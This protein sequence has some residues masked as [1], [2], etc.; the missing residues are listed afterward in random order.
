MGPYSALIKYA[1][2]G[3]GVI[4]LALS[5]IAYGMHRKQQEWD[6]AVMKQAIKSTETVVKQEDNTAKEIIRYIKIKG[7]T[8][9]VNQIVEKRVTEYVY[10]TDP[11][12]TLSPALEREFDLVSRLYDAPPDGVSAASEPSGNPDERPAATATCA[13]LLQAYRHAAKGWRELWDQ[14]HPLTEWE[15]SNYTIARTGSGHAPILEGVLE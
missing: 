13:Q 7:K 11:N 2:M 12:C 15:R 4:A 8:E 14:Y 5:L 1:A 6:A 9:I 3:L 10:T